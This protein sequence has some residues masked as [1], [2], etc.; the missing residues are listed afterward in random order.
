MEKSGEN[1]EVSGIIYARENI[2]KKVP[3]EILEIDEEG[4]TENEYE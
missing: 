2:A 4:T 3:T 1:Y